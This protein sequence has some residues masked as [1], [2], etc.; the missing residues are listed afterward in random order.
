MTTT[1]TTE[2][3]D[4]ADVQRLTAQALRN[5]ADG[6]DAGRLVARSF[7]SNGYPVVTSNGHPT[8]T[9]YILTLEVVGLYSLADIHEGSAL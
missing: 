6:L 4:G 5:L 9:E 8:I 1:V 2:L 3:V 7:H